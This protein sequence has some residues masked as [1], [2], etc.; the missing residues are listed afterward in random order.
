MLLATYQ[1]FEPDE[2]KRNSQ[3]DCFRDMLYGEYPIFCFPARTADEFRFRSLLAAPRKPERLVIFDTD[4]FV[5]FDAVTWNNI[6]TLSRDNSF[7]EKFDGMFID[8]DERFSEYVVQ[9]ERLES[10]LID[11]DIRQL[12]EDDVVR[13]NSAGADDMFDML[14]RKAQ[15]DVRQSLPPKEVLELYPKHDLTAILYQTMFVH[16][17]AGIMWCIA[18]N[19]SEVNLIDTIPFL[20]DGDCV[21]SVAAWNRFGELRKKIFDTD[22]G[23]THEEYLEMC[24]ALADS[25]GG[26]RKAFLC[27]WPRNAPCPCG[28]GKKLKKCH[29][30]K[31]IELFPF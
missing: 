10:P 2:G 14:Q 7:K 19:E 29:G 1:P 25:I 21:S 11:L 17:L 28:S 4:D 24:A 27:R 5:R 3:Y 13:S 16:Y 6:L 20:P 18:A 23:G 30:L 22:L 31:N 15:E 26:N 8:V 12:V 9:P